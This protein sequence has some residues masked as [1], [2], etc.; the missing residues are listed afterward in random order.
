MSNRLTAIIKPTHSCNIACR[1]C[2]VGDCAEN[3]RMNSQT[4]ENMTRELTS[5]PGKEEIN[6]LWH[7]G[8][9]LLMGIDF[10]KSAVEFQKKHQNGREIRNT[11][12]SNAILVNDDYLDFFEENRFH[13]GS[14]LDGPE[15]IHDL[16]RVYGDGSGSFRD[17]WVGLQKIWERNKEI[18][19]RKKEGEKPFHMGGGVITI[20]TKRNI[21]RINEM[22]DFFKAN[23]LSFKINPLIRSGKACGNYEDMGIGPAEYGHALVQL[24]D[25]W[26]DETEEGIDVDPLSEILG[27]L[28]TGK[29]SSCSSCESCVDGFI[30]VGPRGDVYPCGRFDGIKEY[31]LGNI[32]ESSLSQIINSETHMRMASR[33]SDN[34]TSCLVCPYRNI[35]NSGCMHN[36]Y[37]VRGKIEDNDY[38][39]ASYRILFEHIEKALDGELLK[40]KSEKGGNN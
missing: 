9:P 28:M 27:D 12:Q 13:I 6:F 34:I 2:Y 37:M 33:R 22:Y 4:L 25:R 1:Y 8:E 14:S 29:S 17:V 15:E 19:R 24:F 26:F 40:V 39:C 35:C 20:L 3:G 36:A 10:Y 7:G 18:R 30:S 32:N 11:M 16:N 5:I 31:W 21:G 23:N 38:Y